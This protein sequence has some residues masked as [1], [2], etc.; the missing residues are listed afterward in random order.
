VVVALDAGPTLSALAVALTSG[1]VVE[2]AGE[3]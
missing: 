3:G 2:P 1:S